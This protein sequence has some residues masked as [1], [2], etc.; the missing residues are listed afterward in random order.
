MIVMIIINICDINE[1]D[2]KAG[3][4]FF[5]KPRKSANPI[6]VMTNECNHWLLPF[7]QFRYVFHHTPPRPSLSV[8]EKKEKR[9][10][11][12][13][14]KEKKR[15]EEENRKVK[16]KRQKRWRKGLTVYD[17]LDR[18]VYFIRLS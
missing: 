4:R 13:V 16:E 1:V 12:K 8:I 17:K 11:R 14:K 5:F 15:K 10:K 18:L 6:D 9:E 7:C 2:V 3:D